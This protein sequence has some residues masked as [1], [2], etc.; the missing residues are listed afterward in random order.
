MAYIS[1]EFDSGAVQFENSFF[2]AATAEYEPD[3]RQQL[4]FR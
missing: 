4:S 1:G 3:G 2:T